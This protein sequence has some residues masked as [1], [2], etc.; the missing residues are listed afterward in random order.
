M[1]ADIKFRELEISRFRGFDYIKL[2]DLTNVNVF[3]GANNVGK[4]SVLEAISMLIGMENPL[5][6]TRIN[7]WR[8]AASDLENTRYLF[9][10]LDFNNPPLLLARTSD[11]GRRL[12][13][14]SVMRDDLDLSGKFSSNIIE[15]LDF[16]FDNKLEG[17]YR[18]HTSLLL[19]YSN[20]LKPVLDENFKKDLFGIFIPAEKSDLNALESFTI[21]AKRNKK[22][23]VI[24][25]L[26]KFDAEIE[27]IEALRD[28]LYVKMT[29]ISEL[30]PISMAGDGLR[31][32]VNILS[33][34]ACEDYNLVLIDEI[35][36]GLHY[37]AH[38]LMWSVLLDFIKDRDI[39]LFTTTHNLEC[40][41]SLDS[42]VDS[43]NSLKPLVGVYNI[44]KTKNEGF[45]A[46]KYS[47]SELREAIRNEIEIR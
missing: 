9:H 10:N 37:R 29:G 7:G 17:D 19:D 2:A 25:A 41:E 39:Q 26:R 12:T 45:Q 6:P 3:V 33:S 5:L 35:D 16:H 46:Y 8:S 34:I 21:L 40:I 4:S 36:T 24:D 42:V 13:F 47:A 43:N 14:S 31:R 30:I 28:G 15:R 32:L 22:Q 44:T 18:Y 23:V 38:K 11:G 1:G 20:R 27:N